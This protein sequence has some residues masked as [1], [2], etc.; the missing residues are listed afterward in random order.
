[1]QIN[2]YRLNHRVCT[3]AEP[4]PPS[5]VLFCT[6]PI[7]RQASD[8]PRRPKPRTELTKSDRLRPVLFPLRWLN[9]RALTLRFQQPGGLFWGGL[10]FPLRPIL[11]FIDLAQ[12]GENNWQLGE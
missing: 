12:S 4:A 1:M 10:M 2:K 6:R 9:S 5:G 11:P 3:E 8:R 7:V